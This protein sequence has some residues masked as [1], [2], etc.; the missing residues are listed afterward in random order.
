M[1]TTRAKIIRL[2]K[3]YLSDNSYVKGFITCEWIEKLKKELD[4]KDLANM[5][6]MVYL[7]L[8]H[9][10]DYYDRNR[11]FK[12]AMKW[13]DVQSAFTEVVNKVARERRQ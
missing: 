1:E 7:T 12:E 8:E 2:A 13:M 11:D 4:L 5:W 3:E 9:Q 10:F 6:D